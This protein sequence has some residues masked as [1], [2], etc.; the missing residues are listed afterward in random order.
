MNIPNFVRFWFE[1]STD[2]I[3]ASQ[4]AQVRIVFLG[5]RQKIAR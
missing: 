4:Y 2:A 3:A 1:E 5:Q